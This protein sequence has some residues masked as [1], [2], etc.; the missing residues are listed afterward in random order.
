MRFSRVWF[1][2]LLIAL[3]GVSVTP[4]VAL[5][6]S[7]VNKPSAAR[8]VVRV[9]DFEEQAFNSEPVPRYWV[10]GQDNP[11]MRPR[12]GF[13]QWNK[14]AFDFTQ[15]VSGAESVKL[16]TRG[17]NASLRLAPGVIPVI[18]GG[19]YQIT[20]QLRTEGLT[21]ARARLVAQYTDADFQV[22]STSQRSTARLNTGGE[23]RLISVELPNNEPNAVWLTIDLEILQPS[24]FPASASRDQSVNPDAVV[25][26]VTG[27]AWFDDVTVR[28]VPIVSLTTS[29]P[30]G[31]TLGSTSPALRTMVDDVVG[32]HLSAELRLIDL[33]GVIVDSFIVDPVSPGVEID[34]RPNF[35]A[36]GWHRAEF[37]I[38]SDKK[39]IIADSR[40]LLWLP[41]PH[42]Q[43]ERARMGLILDKGVEAPQ[44]AL[45]DL[46][47]AANVGAVDMPYW[48]AGATKEL[49]QA[50]IPRLTSLLEELLTRRLS[51][52]FS[53]DRLPADLANE[54]RIDDHDILNALLADRASWAP[55]LDEALARFGQRV[56]RWRLGSLEDRTLPAPYEYADSFLKAAQPLSLSVQS[57][58]PTI[59]WP[60]QIQP[61]DTLNSAGVVL[62]WPAAL[63]PLSVLD[64]VPP[65]G[66]F[67]EFSIVIDTSSE[68]DST[69]DHSRAASIDLARRAIRAWQANPD[70]IMIPHPWDW[71][72]HGGTLLAEPLPELGVWSNLGEHLRGRRVVGQLPIAPGAVAL[73]LDS[74]DGSGGAIVAWNEWAQPADAHINAFL[75]D[76]P[77]QVVDLMGNQTSVAAFDGAHHVNLTQAPVFLEGI[78][79]K[80]AS[81]RAGFTVEPAHL[82]STAERHT[83][84]L[85]VTNPWP[86]AIN[87]SLRL[88]EPASWSFSPQLVHFTIAPGEVARFPVETSFGL[89]EEAGVHQLRAEVRLNASKQYPTIAVNAAIDL[90]LKNIDLLPSYQ[91]RRSDEG[92]D[93]IVTLLVV[94]TGQEST[95]L[96]T[97]AQAPNMKRQQAPI[98]DLPPRGAA[99]RSFVFR[100][101]ADDLEGADVQ[102][103]I[104]E[105]VGLGRLT[106]RLHIE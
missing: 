99:V 14:A 84:S 35:P 63:P 21:H 32:D 28:I 56:R 80:L 60:A 66:L 31:V 61:P 78:D 29:S 34:W 54:Q 71:S 12:P 64:L 6:Q 5:G 70:R 4:P 103:G 88:V 2:P 69:P 51:V 77:I 98:S 38:L 81:F 16:F 49:L 27:A 45:V 3:V 67:G 11:P 46:L 20:A 24:A 76:H 18:P 75:A 59:P 39:L 62:T 30:S 10:R 42:N 47:R 79:A 82:E 97:Y 102:V 92:D 15:S 94:N 57:P 72:N 68:A 50:Q 74:D 86:V 106:R 25:E 44:A 101:A 19:E 40:N 52:T 22:I 73:V 1:A 37:D 58:L 100:H 95:T 65:P 85:V 8:R 23:W 93:V 89:S 17:G 104:I 91:I 90:G 87:G 13:P 53:L 9:F 26:D 55:W 43:R 83:I 41:E 105:S 7:P 48:R 36:Y 33:D 96:M